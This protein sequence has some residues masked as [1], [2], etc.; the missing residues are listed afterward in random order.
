MLDGMNSRRVP[1][2]AVVF[3]LDAT[4]VDSEPNCYEAARRL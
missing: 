2:P 4:L 1:V 3:D